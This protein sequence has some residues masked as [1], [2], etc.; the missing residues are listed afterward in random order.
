MEHEDKKKSFY[1]LVDD[2]YSW[3]TVQSADGRVPFNAVIGGESA[4]GE[5]Y[6]IGRACHEGVWTP[7]KI[8]TLDKCLYIPF[9]CEELRF[10]SYYVLVRT[11]KS[12][13]GSLTSNELN[14]DDKSELKSFRGC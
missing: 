4:T 8:D 2:G 1:I 9:G 13:N 11:T 12:F 14:E 3:D 6:Y 5:A 10:D 7:G